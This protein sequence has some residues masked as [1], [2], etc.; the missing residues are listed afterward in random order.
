MNSTLKNSRVIV[1][2]WFHRNYQ[3]LIIVSLVS[4]MLSLVYFM[5]EIYTINEK[6]ISGIKLLFY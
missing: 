5:I 1:G 2:F 4:C 6:V 3:V